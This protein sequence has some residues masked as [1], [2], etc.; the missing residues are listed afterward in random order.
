MDDYLRAVVL[1]LV[2]AVTEF[3]PI[4][5]S[6]HLVLA[7]EVIGGDV[8][9]LTFDVGLHVGTTT[10]VIAYFWRD[11]VTIGTHGLH[12]VLRHGAAVG[13][14]SGPA[15]LGLWIVLGTIPAVVVG[16]LF[17]QPIDDHLREPWL[18][19][20]MLIAAGLVIDVADRR[21]GHAG[22]LAAVGGRHALVVG[23]AQAAA[24]VPGVSRSGA[25][26]AAGRALG[27]ER[28]AAARFSFLLSAPAVVG[29]A[30][31]QLWEA[32]S[33]DEAVRWGPLWVG[34]A[35]AAVAG[36]VVIGWF[37]RA[38]AVISLRRF[39]WYRIGLGALVLALVAAGAL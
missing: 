2:Q 14:W 1:G 23:V 26:I 6:G 4:S 31:L 28:P 3:L 17:E 7:P 9:S 36:W 39:V 15:R 22:G 13:R 38:L 11:W 33:G 27:M 37:L 5:S 19:G 16:G 12:D 18:V 35:V 34:A 25:T 30:T 20:V 8:S 10:A 24:L 32:S 21:G 29:A